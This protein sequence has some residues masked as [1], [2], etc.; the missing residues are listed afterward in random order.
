MDRFVAESPDQAASAVPAVISKV[1]SI[2]KMELRE[3]MADLS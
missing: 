1:N 2:K 3:R